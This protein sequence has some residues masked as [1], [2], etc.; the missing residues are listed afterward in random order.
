[1]R[2]VTTVPAQGAWSPSAHTPGAC[3]P[4]VLT[5]SSRRRTLL[6][7]SLGLGA[8]LLASPGV[9][10][11]AAAQGAPHPPADRSAASVRPTVLTVSGRLRKPGPE[12]RIDLD[13]AALAALPQQAF[14][15]RTPWFDR[16]R[17]FSGPLLRDVLVLAGAQGDRLRLWALNDYRVDLPFSDA[18]RY[19][20][21]LAR[22]LDGQPM[23]VR[24][25][26][27]LFVIYPF[28]QV[29]DLHD[30]SYYSRSAWQLRTIEV[31]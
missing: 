7:R 22:L 18:Q 28:D 10:T 15:T 24:D 23:R 8:G 29:P 12:G 1:M 31:L 11:L 26:G 6:L 17:R 14:S 21:L 9:W 19:D 27:P 4:G 20:V 2:S 5:A 30:V 25:K 13:M 16:P 3:P